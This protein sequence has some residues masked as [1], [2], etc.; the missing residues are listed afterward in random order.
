MPLSL[1]NHDALLL[2]N[3][4]PLVLKMRDII[5]AGKK[6]LYGQFQETF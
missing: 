5:F 3:N 6:K 1:E 4:V 2:T